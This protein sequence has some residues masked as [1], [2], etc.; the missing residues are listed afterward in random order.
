MRKN[1]LNFNVIFGVIMIIL[2]IVCIIRF[3]V[4][5]GGAG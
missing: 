1:G 5:L 3:F 4:L 2:A